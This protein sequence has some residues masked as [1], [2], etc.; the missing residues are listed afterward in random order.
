ML[1]LTLWTNKKK[2]LKEK[3]KFSNF[4]LQWSLGSHGDLFFEISSSFAIVK[5]KETLLVILP[6]VCHVS[7][8]V[9][10]DSVTAW[11][12]CSLSGSSVHE[13]L[14]ARILEWIALSFYSPFLHSSLL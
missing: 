13:T 8:S 2:L 12:V 11:T 4:V 6:V 10:S 3:E 5:L 7:C 9:V 1:E 14:Q